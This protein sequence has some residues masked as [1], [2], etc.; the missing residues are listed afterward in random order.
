MAVKLKDIDG[1]LVKK[2]K[3][4]KGLCSGDLNS[5]DGHNQAITQQGEVSIG[6]NRQKLFDIIHRNYRTAT[7]ISF[8]IADAIIANEK[9]IFEVRK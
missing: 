8:E 4:V 5:Y 7:P 1:A 6:L 9:E 3:L 2:K